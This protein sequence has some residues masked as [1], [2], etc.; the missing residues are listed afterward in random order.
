MSGS[1]TESSTDRCPVDHASREKWSKLQQAAPEPLSPTA[2]L[3]TA[4]ETSSIPREDGHKWVYPS[5]AQFYDA[6]ARKKH[7]PRA[8]D[9]QVVVPIHNAV[10]ER[11]WQE[12][13][14]WEAGRGGEKCGGVKLVSFKGDASKTSPKARLKMLF[15]YQAPFDRHDWLVDRCGTQM[16]YVIDFYTG[17]PDSATMS[18]AGNLS[19]Y[20]DVR[21]S[22]D[23]FEGIKMRIGMFWN[24]WV[25]GTPSPGT[26][27]ARVDS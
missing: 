1:H 24:R 3:P 8:G 6:M 21:P 23:S 16:R 11:A 4:R 13:L 20:L 12:V 25:L 22:L 10:N 17:R 15:G 27:P 19:F 7:N 18:P 26:L 9:M 14:K 5:Q 2:G